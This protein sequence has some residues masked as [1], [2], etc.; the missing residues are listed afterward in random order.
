MLRQLH[1]LPDRTR[2]PRRPLA[3]MSH[4]PRPGVP[5]TPATHA[6]KT[7]LRPRIRLPPHHLQGRTRRTRTTTASPH[8]TPASHPTPSNPTTVS[9]SPA[10][11]PTTNGPP[12]PSPPPTSSAKPSPTTGIIPTGLYQPEPTQMGKYIADFVGR[13]RLGSRRLNPGTN[14][15]TPPRIQTALRPTLTGRIDPAT[16]HHP[17]TT[18]ASAGPHYPA[19]SRALAPEVATPHFP[20]ISGSNRPLTGVPD[21]PQR[22]PSQGARITSSKMRSLP[23]PTPSKKGAR[24]SKK[25]LHLA[26]LIHT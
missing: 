17:P 2:P 23:L 10:S 3:P 24:S 14:T 5:P 20:A 4:S 22:G 1:P 18:R 7:R 26:G 25:S 11:G 9:S 19:K 12:S 8:K 21:T 16:R 13:K 15:T 6:S